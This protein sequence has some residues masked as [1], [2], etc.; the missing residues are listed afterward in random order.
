MNAVLVDFEKHT[1]LGPTRAAKLLGVAYCTYA[2]IRNGRRPMQR[3]TH[4][5]IEAI[6]FLKSDALDGLIRKHVYG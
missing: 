3:Y 4:R 1:G 6:R 2:Q 5:H